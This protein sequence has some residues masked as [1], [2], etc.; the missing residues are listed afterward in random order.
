MYK[1]FCA[2]M[3]V[4]CTGRVTMT[5]FLRLR[6]PFSMQAFSVIIQFF[7]AAQTGIVRNILLGI[8]ANILVS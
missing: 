8:I 1:K 5:D 2:P 4:K 6:F 3:E 7:W